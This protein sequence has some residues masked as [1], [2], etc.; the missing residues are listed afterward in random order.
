MLPFMTENQGVCYWAI[1]LDSC[2]DPPVR[3]KT[4]W[5]QAWLKA[6]DCFSDFLLAIVWD[7]GVVARGIGVTVTRPVP[8]P[9]IRRLRRRYEEYPRTSHWPLDHVYRF[10][11]S[12][13]RIWVAA[14]PRVSDWFLC[15]KSPLDLDT[16]IK[17]VA[18]W[19][20]LPNSVDKWTDY[21][22]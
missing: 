5:N 17:E 14:S 7:A 19:A 13:C 16:Q 2:D 4:T 3:I 8:Y 10:Q 22:T 15:S 11:R 9:V 12:S 18:A 1:E 20:G 21:R 6:C